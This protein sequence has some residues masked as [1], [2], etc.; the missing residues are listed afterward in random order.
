MAKALEIDPVLN[1]R[2]H[3]GNNIADLRVQT[4]E[5]A[6][7]HEI[8][9][10]HDNSACTGDIVPPH[11]TIACA[12][13]ASSFMNLLASRCMYCMLPMLHDCCLRTMM[14]PSTAA[15]Q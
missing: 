3:V 13:S 2:E 10:K 11:K 14:R 9:V 5:I 7:E 1:G 8:A 6:V 15:A 12:S 4:N